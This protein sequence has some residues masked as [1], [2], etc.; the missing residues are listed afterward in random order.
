[1]RRS[2]ATADLE[3]RVQALAPMAR[4][5]PAARAA[6]LAQGEQLSLVA[7][8]ILYRQGEE[9]GYVHFLLS[10]VLEV[11]IGGSRVK[12]IDERDKAATRALDPAGPKPYTLRA[13]S[14]STV[15]RLPRAAL[16]R[17]LAETPD[18]MQPVA[19]RAF[20]PDAPV[21]LAHL[22]RSDL[23]RTL[24]AANLEA[25]AERL[26]PLA[27]RAG[28][29]ILHE[30]EPGDHCY[31]LV[32]GSARV[33][34]RL[35]DGR[36]MHLADLGPGDAFGEEAL[37]AEAPQ[38]ATV[39]MTTDGRL[40]RLGRGH[41]NALVRAPL[42]RRVPYRQAR[43]L[44]AEGAVWLDVRPVEA[45]ARGA[46]EG[47]VNV[48]YPALR[49]QSQGLPRH[50]SYIVCSDASG[51]SAAG[52]FFLASRGLDASA[53][54]EPFSSVWGQEQGRRPDTREAGGGRDRPQAG[55]ARA[56]A[57]EGAEPEAGGRRAQPIEPAAHPPPGGGPA[58]FAPERAPERTP[59]RGDAGREES[60]RDDAQPDTA[61]PDDALQ[62]IVMS[63]ESTRQTAAGHAPDSG[64]AR[65][66]DARSGD[67]RSGDTRSG[68]TR[69]E[70]ARREAASAGDSGA[71][72]KPPA[73]DA[74]EE[75]Q[76]FADTL[77]GRT[78]VDL[79]NQI[80]GDRE[81]L[82]E[83]SLGEGDDGDPAAAERALAEAAGA[84]EGERQG[85]G[86]GD[87]AL[88]DLSAVL[89]AQAKGGHGSAP[90]AQAGGARA[91]PPPSESPAEQD[92]LAALTSE[93]ETRLRA[94]LE[95]G[96]ERARAEAEARV[97][98]RL[99]RVQRAA[100]R[101]V[102]RQAEAF[103]Q[104]YRAHYR[105]SENKLRQQ[106][107]KLVALA[108]KVARQKVEVQQARR[109]LAQ[110]VEATQRLQ[111]EIDELRT[112]LTTHLGNIEEL[113]SGED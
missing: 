110:K 37:V 56:A 23:F 86:E 46:F 53:L 88:V 106:Y 31:L 71:A 76:D 30:G 103:R 60:P 41:F 89:E 17:A 2:G 93:F 105:E 72:R 39:T 38:G 66:G 12:R 85:E 44:V 7:G 92:E 57:I 22:R 43:D 29:T 91:E 18:H 109:E 15:L 113:E 54:A 104:R 16:E 111:R 34:R 74:A 102:K 36:P 8:E 40:L 58:H 3:P 50:K 26:E 83:R 64:D 70:G 99:E 1:M 55:Q 90:P 87:S 100:A 35:A 51:T 28:E 84:P 95:R 78:L 73:G 11:V 98:A 25:I 5:E 4:L 10:G 24:P 47:A 9:D 20:S 82:S 59:E 21:W 48:P 19:R 81:Q 97:A 101:E 108:D 61:H 42:V 6:L 45:F 77:I 14:A 75:L 63:D 27:A 33:S 94:C 67:A 68:D 65:S 69:R 52:A 96:A 80:E 112:I 32:E 79:V 107:D 62:D 13:E 49:A